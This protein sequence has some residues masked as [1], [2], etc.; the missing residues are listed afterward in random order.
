MLGTPAKPH[1]GSRR[2]QAIPGLVTLTLNGGLEWATQARTR[3][4]CAA[5]AR[6]LTLQR[7][8]CKRVASNNKQ[9]N[10]KANV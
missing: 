1:P 10:D 2:G 3:N 7:A 5:A 6:T 8:R 9:V 4:V